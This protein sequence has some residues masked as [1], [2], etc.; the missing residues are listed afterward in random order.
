MFLTN[1]QMFTAF[2]SN[3]YTLADYKA[4]LILQNPTN[5]TSN[6]V[7]NLFFQYHY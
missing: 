4:K 3:I 6:F 2:Q 5:P 1:Q 7:T